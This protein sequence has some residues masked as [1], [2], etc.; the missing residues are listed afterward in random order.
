M[1][2]STTRT[3]FGGGDAVALGRRG[4][5]MSQK[6]RRFR[7]KHDAPR[8]G[9]HSRLHRL[10]NVDRRTKEGKLLEEVRRELLAHIGPNPN[11]IQR[12]L[13]TRA[14]ILSLRLAQID[15]KIFEER[16]FTVID[17]AQTVAWQNALTKCL[18]ALGVPVEAP[19]D[20][21]SINRIMAELDH[22]G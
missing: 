14:C 22:G 5:L 17:N 13:I 21:A 1:E 3:G 15:R 2:S 6:K 10:E 11:A 18:R 8:L 20:D 7:Y 9:P 4:G 16:E 19:K 12:L